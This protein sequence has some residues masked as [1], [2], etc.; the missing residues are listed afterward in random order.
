MSSSSQIE[1]ELKYPVITQRLFFKAQELGDASATVESLGILDGDML[2][3]YAV[4]MDGD[5][6]PSAFED[7]PSKRKSKRA[8]EEGF[9]GTGL[10]GF[11]EEDGSDDGSRSGAGGSNEAAEEGDVHSNG[12]GGKRAKK[13]PSPS[14]AEANSDLEDVDMDDQIPCP[15]CT[16]LNNAALS[17]CEMCDS[18]LKG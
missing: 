15:S 13:A 18:D 12:R 14:T 9:S 11:D 1:Q 4:G 2:E 8:R 7:K 5:Y 16:F 17:S 3:V 10:F 6:D